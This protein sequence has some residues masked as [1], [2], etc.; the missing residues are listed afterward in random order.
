[1]MDS[2]L[3]SPPFFER[4]SR[5]YSDMD[6]AYSDAAH[7]YA[8]HCKGCDRNC[9]QERF[10]HYT[11][12]EH[13]FLAHG[14]AS[15]G[16]KTKTGIFLRADE[17]M[18]QY[19]LHDASNQ[20]ERAI[21]PLNLEGLC[22]LYEYRPMICRLQGIAHYIKKPGQP[23]KRGPGCHVFNEKI[24]PKNL[25]DF[26][27][28]HTPFYL[29]MVAIEVEIRNRLNYKGRYKKTVAEMLLNIRDREMQ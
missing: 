9:C 19:R 28:D 4:I 20:A 14:L 6:K 3:F 22:V 23:Q 2:A 25:S 29:E 24:L 26:S 8:F 17:V 27:F 16:Q 12:A 7:Y 21:C 10:Y 13:V 18:L 1:M 11:A 15:L 5:L